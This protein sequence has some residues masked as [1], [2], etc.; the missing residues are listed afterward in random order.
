MLRITSSEN[1]LCKQKFVSS[2]NTE[3][4]CQSVFS[5][6]RH[7][8]LK[9]RTTLPTVSSTHTFKNWFMI[10]LPLVLLPHTFNSHKSLRPSV[11][12]IAAG[13]RQLSQSWFRQNS[14][15][16]FMSHDSGVMQLPSLTLYSPV[17]CC[18]PS[19]ALSLLVSGPVGNQDHIFVRSRRSRALNWG[20][21]FDER[22]GLN[23]TG[24][25]LLWPASLIEWRADC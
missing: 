12:Y 17:N 5:N 6:Q 20:L 19:P 22:R 10:S 8:R 9:L 11:K 13:P 1:Q 15:P 25:L 2:R 21:L 3:T 24:A 16:H 18:W 4:V 14:W 23:T 7:C